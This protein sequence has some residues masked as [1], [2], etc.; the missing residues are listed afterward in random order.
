VLRSGLQSSPGVTQVGSTA[1]AI[2]GKIGYLIDPALKGK[3]PGPFKVTAI[4]L[5]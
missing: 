3:D 2:E 4:P 1:Y 5:R